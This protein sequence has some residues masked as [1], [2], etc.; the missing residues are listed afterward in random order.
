MTRNTLH[1]FHPLI[2][3][4]TDHHFIYITTCADGHKHQLQS[5]YKLMEED[6][7]DI[8]KDWSGDLLIPSDPAEI[9][10]IDSP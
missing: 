4:N 7:E 8:T 2:K 3:F 9:Y 5:Y 1:R 6:L 10:D